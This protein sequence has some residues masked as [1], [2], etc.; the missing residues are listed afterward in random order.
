MGNDSW[1]GD[2][3]NGLRKKSRQRKRVKEKLFLREEGYR[4]APA[5][6]GMYRWGEGCEKKGAGGYIEYLYQK[7]LIRPEEG[8]GT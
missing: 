7:P 4:G 1:G 8:G 2:K 3:G 5:R 6:G